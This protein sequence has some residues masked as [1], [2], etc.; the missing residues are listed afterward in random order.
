MSQEIEIPLSKNKLFLGIAASLLFVVLGGWFLVDTQYFQNHPMRFLR[1]P[2]VPQIVGVVSILFFG[3]TGIYGIKKVLDKKMGVVIDQYGITDHS[4]GTSVGLIEWADITS[5]DV[6]TIMSTKFLLLHVKDSE[7]YI[8]KARNK[9]QASLMRTNMK[10]YRT[11]L[12]VNSNTLK[13]NFETL[14]NEVRSA[15]EKH[16]NIS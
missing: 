5:I 4:S 3:I 13:C 1:N 6:H 16:K 7:K 9:I 11:P 14:E 12:S 2:L 8:E 15:F 10:T